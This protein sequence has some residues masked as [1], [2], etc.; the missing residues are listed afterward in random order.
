MLVYIQQYLNLI[1]SSAQC[2]KKKKKKW[3]PELCGKWKHLY[4]K[5]FRYQMRKKANKS[6]HLPLITARCRWHTCA[7]PSGS[8]AAPRCVWLGA[9]CLWTARSDPGSETTTYGQIRREPHL[10]FNKLPVW[11]DLWDVRASSKKKRN[12]LRWGV[13]LSSACLWCFQFWL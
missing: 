7:A 12:W 11:D 13:K 5:L 8:S 1:C 3:I 6:C 4:Y 2:K 9:S 10:S